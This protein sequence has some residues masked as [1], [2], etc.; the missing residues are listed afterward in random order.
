VSALR[1]KKE[2]GSSVKV[3]SGTSG[4]IE[5]VS[6]A[7]ADI[8]VLAI[9]GSSATLP[10]LEAMRRGKTVAL[11]NKESLVMAGEIIIRAKEKNNARI[12]PIDSEQSAIW[13]CLHSNNRG[14]LRRIYI[15]ASGGPLRRISARRFKNLSS[16]LILRHPKWKMGSKIT[17]DSATLMNKGFEVIETHWLF[18]VDIQRIKVLIHPEV[19]VH[20]MCEFCDGSILAQLAS[21]D[22]RLP[23]QYALSFPRRLESIVESVNFLKLK[24]LTFLKPDEKKFPCLRFAY[25]AAREGGVAPS[26]LNAANE[27]AVNAFLARRIT[28]DRIPYVIEKVLSKKHSR[29]GATL[30]DILHAD[31]WARIKAR[32]IIEKQ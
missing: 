9:S 5:L 21:C 26:V 24:S 16:E 8:I 4:L 31:E 23:I 27:E 28:F 19:V 11:A 29:N 12:L 30:K 2:L 32:S 6:C 14:L 20:S 15:T 7:G 10:M 18:D 1:I 22:M 3:F 13:Q 17:V 25:E